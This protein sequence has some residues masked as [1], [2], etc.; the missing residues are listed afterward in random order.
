MLMRPGF[1]IAIA[2]GLVAIV[3]I[4]AWLV[5]G[6]EDNGGVL[7]EG[8]QPPSSDATSAVAP[9]PLSKIT[10]PPAPLGD[11]LPFGESLNDSLIDEATGVVPSADLPPE[12]MI[13]P[14]GL[15]PEPMLEPNDAAGI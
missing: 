9:G 11:E 6:T 7:A 2:L 8:L 15:E 3:L 12:P 13:I 4:A 14:D 5:V 10:E 1:R